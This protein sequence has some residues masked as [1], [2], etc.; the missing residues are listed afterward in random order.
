MAGAVSER[1][2]NFQEWETTPAEAPF[3]PVSVSRSGFL[4]DEHSL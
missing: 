4:R 2:A 1:K 3:Q